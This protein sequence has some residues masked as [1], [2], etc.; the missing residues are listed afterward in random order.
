MDPEEAQIVVAVDRAT[1]SLS[2]WV[3]VAGEADRPFAGWLGLLAALQQTAALRGPM[4]V[5]AENDPPA[6]KP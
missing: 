6:G 3:R 2:G 4:A 5:A 1:P